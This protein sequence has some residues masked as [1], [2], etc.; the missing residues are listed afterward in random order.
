MIHTSRQLKAL[1]RNMS[2]SDSGKAQVIIRT[3]VMERFLE[4]LFLS[5]FKG[6]RRGIDKKIRGVEPPFFFFQTNH[7]RYNA[8]N[9]EKCPRTIP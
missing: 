3:Y 2:G 9:I 7:P 1:V 8:E 6:W 5:R 4:R